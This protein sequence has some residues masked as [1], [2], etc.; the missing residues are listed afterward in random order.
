M[1]AR[2]YLILSGL[3]LGPYGLYCIFNPMALQEFATLG[4]STPTAITEVRAMYGGLEFSLGLYLLFCGLRTERVAQ[5]LLFMVFCF[6]G[7][8][9]ARAYGL[10]IDGGDTGYNFAALIYEASSGLIALILLQLHNR[11]RETASVS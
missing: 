6:A 5:G 8:A 4:L 1:P 10:A 9:G 11:R 7:L 2:I 3:I